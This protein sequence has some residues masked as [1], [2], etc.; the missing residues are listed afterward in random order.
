MILQVNNLTKKYGHSTILDDI[1]FTLNE[2]E[3]VALVGP[4]GAGKSTLL[5][6][7]TNLEQADSGSIKICGKDHKES[8]VFKDVSYM[9]DNSVLYDYWLA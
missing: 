5:D 1:S 9:Q 4:N 7:L 8:S 3:I 2:G 6:I